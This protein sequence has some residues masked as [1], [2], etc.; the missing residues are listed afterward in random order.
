MTDIF[1]ECVRR[2][3]DHPVGTRGEIVGVLVRQVGVTLVPF[4]AV[5]VGNKQVEVSASS[6][7]R[8]WRCR[9]LDSGA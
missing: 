3:P 4:V 5:Q 6:I 1:A 8:Y 7:S 9:K 2:Y